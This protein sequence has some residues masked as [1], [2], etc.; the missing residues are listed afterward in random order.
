MRTAELLSRQIYTWPARP[1]FFFVSLV[2]F[3]SY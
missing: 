1:P 3:K 2:A